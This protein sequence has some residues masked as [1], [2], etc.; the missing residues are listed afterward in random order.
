M[1]K[2]EYSKFCCDESLPLF[3][4]PW[5]LNIVV[6]ENWSV[7]LAKENGNIIGVL[8]YVFKKK[9]GVKIISQPDFT[10][11]LGPYFSLSSYNR[12]TS[13]STIKKGMYE[14]INNLPKHQIYSQ[15]WH[16]SIKNWL[17]FYWKNFEQTTRYTYRLNNLDDLNL[18]WSNLH[19]NIRREIK[20]AESRYNLKIEDNNNTNDLF[21][22]II[23]TYKRQNKKIFFNLESFKYICEKTIERGNGKILIARDEHG[24]AHAGLFLVWDENCSYYLI[25]GSCPKLRNSGAMSLCM[26][27]AILF[28]SNVSR[29][30]DFEGSMIEDIE[31]YF[32]GFGSTPTEYY[33]IIMVNI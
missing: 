7:C 23:S 16:H 19:G 13:L 4:Q 8:P 12:K 30:F 25:G 14:L 22:L 1:S 2:I 6:G 3:F 17:P 5:W 32:R 18:L 21:K 31:R 24:N 9:L 33:F 26:W 20:K 27:K 11:Y 15:Y 29:A 28:A 10:Q